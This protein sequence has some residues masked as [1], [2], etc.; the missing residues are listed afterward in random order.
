MT[1]TTTINGRRLFKI[2]Y[3][4]SLRGKVRTAY[5]WHRNAEEAKSLVLIRDHE[6]AAKLVDVREL[7]DVEVDLYWRGIW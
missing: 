4:A 5:Q 3:R 7:T 1:S 6:P 2:Q